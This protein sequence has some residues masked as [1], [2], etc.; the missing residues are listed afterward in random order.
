MAACS[1]KEMDLEEN[2]RDTEKVKYAG[3]GGGF[4]RVLE[5]AGK[6]NQVQSPD[7]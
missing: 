1:R 2:C 3:L 4:D 7:F 5:R 6:R